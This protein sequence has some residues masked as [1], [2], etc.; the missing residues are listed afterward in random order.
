MGA[1]CTCANVQ[2]S[3]ANARLTSLGDKVRG[4]I[5]SDSV[6]YLTCVRK[7][8]NCCGRLRFPCL[9]DLKDTKRV[10]SVRDTAL[11]LC[12]LTQDC[13]RID[14]LPGSVHLCVASRG[15]IL[16]SC[17]CNDSNMAMRANSLAVSRVCK[18]R[19]C[20]SFSLARFVHGGCN[21]SNVGQRG[22]LVDLAS[23]RDAAAFGRIV[24]AGS[25]RR[26]ERYELSME[27]GVCGRR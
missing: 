14:R 7:L 25:P 19:A 8:A 10:I 21:A 1:S 2:R 12:P 15:G 18:G 27:F 16:R 13:G 6:N 22:L 3:P 23:R 5:R 20:C 24:F 11:C 17:M 9:G 4:L 26:R